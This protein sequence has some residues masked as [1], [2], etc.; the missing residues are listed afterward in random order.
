MTL[1]DASDTLRCQ[2]RNPDVFSLSPAG[3]L[4][5]IA[6]GAKGCC[7]TT[8]SSAVKNMSSIKSSDFNTKELL[9]IL[10]AAHDKIST[11]HADYSI[12]LRSYLKYCRDVVF[13][14]MTTSYDE[15]TLIERF[16]ETY[17]K[18]E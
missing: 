16:W 17:D 12:D 9:D 1:L 8:N 18:Q 7:F 4:G 11:A 15:Q 14:G 2:T 10:Q 5:D 6:G 3:K 13:A